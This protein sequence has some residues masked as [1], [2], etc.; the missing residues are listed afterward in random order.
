MSDD[1][2][3]GRV[4]DGLAGGSE[5]AARELMARTYG[6]IVGLVRARIGRRFLAKVDADSVANSVLKTFVRRH[7]D[8]PYALTDWEDLWRLLAEIARHKLSNRL[9]WHRQLKRNVDGE[10]PLGE[11]DPAGL[12]A[13][14]DAQAVVDDLCDHLLGGFGE[15]ERVVIELSVQGYTVEEIAARVGASGRTVIRVRTK[16]RKRL[17]AERD[18]AGE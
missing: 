12:T 6:R 2:D 1:S 13:G 5:T 14:P 18:A 3:F 8:D 16:F 9:R 17:E 15:A 4:A 10:T 7:T 11:H